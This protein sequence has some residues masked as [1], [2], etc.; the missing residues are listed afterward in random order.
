MLKRALSFSNRRPRVERP[1]SIAPVTY[2]VPLATDEPI[3]G[4]SNRRRNTVG[5][6]GTS[7]AHRS[8]PVISGESRIL[9]NSVL[10]RHGADAI[11]EIYREFPTIFNTTSS[12]YDTQDPFPIILKGPHMFEQVTTNLYET[13]YIGNIRRVIN[14]LP[15]TETF[16]EDS[17]LEIMRRLHRAVG[18]FIHEIK[19][20]ADLMT[21][22]TVNMAHKEQLMRSIRLLKEMMVHSHADQFFTQ[23]I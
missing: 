18:N 2:V 22:R 23:H 6:P 14:G 7:R 4:N 1:P 20:K 8:E 5:L 15:K 21:G 9:H 17:V 10:I 16:R 13:E 3:L 11:D 12:K 19:E